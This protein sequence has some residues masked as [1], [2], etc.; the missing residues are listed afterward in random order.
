MHICYELVYLDITNKI[1][2][3]AGNPSKDLL[4]TV[5]AIYRLVLIRLMPWENLSHYFV[6]RDIVT[7]TYVIPESIYMFSGTNPYRIALIAF[8]EI[9]L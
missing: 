2:L 7:N 8:S 3:A 6:V 4:I 9:V 5:G 1:R